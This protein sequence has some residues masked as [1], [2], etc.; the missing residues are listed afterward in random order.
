MFHAHPNFGCRFSRIS[1]ELTR[2]TDREYIAGVVKGEIQRL[3]REFAASPE[4][5]ILIFLKGR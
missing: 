3:E 1:R 5:Q 4:K 2:S